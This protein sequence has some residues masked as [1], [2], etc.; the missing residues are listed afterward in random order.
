MMPT[1]LVDYCCGLL[2]TVLDW[3]FAE[4][5]KT[6]LNI[7]PYPSHHGLLA[8]FYPPPVLVR[9]LRQQMLATMSKNAAHSKRNLLIYVSRE[10]QLHRAI[11]RD[12]E[13]LVRLR[14]VATEFGL[15]LVQFVGTKFKVRNQIEL[16]HRAK[17]IIGPHGASL[18]NML[19]S[20]M[21]VQAT[22]H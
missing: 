16:F 10:T 1:T 11:H 7:E 12:G 4:R 9:A 5:T 3:R 21:S 2:T 6:A 20:R 18:A 22:P 13:L 15:E 14:S 19:F 17:L 8:A